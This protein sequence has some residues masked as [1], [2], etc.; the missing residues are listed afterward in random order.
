MGEEKSVERLDRLIAK[1]EAVL[2]T[3]RPNPPNVIGFPTLD[4]GAFAEWRTQSL[5]CLV[6]VLGD[7]HVYVENFKEQIKKGYNGT[8]KAGIGILKATKEDIAAGHLD[9]APEQSPLLL[10]EQICSRFHLVARQL[11]SRH[12]GRGTLDVQDEYDVQ[13]L[14]H[15][16]LCLNFVDIRPEEYTPSYAGKASR[17][18]FLLK[19]ESIVIEL[20]MT[21]S[22]L[23]PRELSTQLI[24][25]IERYKTHPD[26][27]A[28]VCFVYDPAGLIPNP[29]GIEADLKRDEGPF[30]V[31]VL[32]R[33]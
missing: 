5:S 4:S 33:P 16:L 12:G 29:R 7:A 15:A 11:R 8:V 31:R 30:P 13:D 26:C 14:M 20:K 2:R 28:L 27:Q 1:G 19:Q 10:I 24:E 21:R 18:D 25:D 6:T 17:M 32:I 23:G 22:G 3:H 9:K